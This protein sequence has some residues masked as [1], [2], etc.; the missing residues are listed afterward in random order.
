MSNDAHKAWFPVVGGGADQLVEIWAVA[1]DYSE[2]SDLIYSADHVSRSHESELES[3]VRPSR[4]SEG[5]NPRQLKRMTKLGFEFESHEVTITGESFGLATVLV[6]KMARYSDALRVRLPALVATATVDTKGIVGPFNSPDQKKDF[7]KKV[8][9]IVAK[10][11]TNAQGGVFLVS[12]QQ[13]VTAEQ[14]ESLKEAGIRLERIGHI[15]E[16]F[17]QDWLWQFHPVLKTKEPPK[18]SSPWKWVAGAASV[19]MAAFFIGTN[20]TPESQGEGIVPS[21]IDCKAALLKT[22]DLLRCGGV[23]ARYDLKLKFRKSPTDVFSDWVPGITLKEKQQF[24]L[25]FT[26]L[27]NDSR[28][29]YL[30]LLS[31]YPNNHTDVADLMPMPQCSDNG[32]GPFEMDGGIHDDLYFVATDNPAPLIEKMHHLQNASND[33]KERWEF[34]LRKWLSYE[35]GVKSFVLR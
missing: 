8:S 20:Q 1:A 14:A 30:L 28:H 15:D 22:E 32:C 18:P 4:S 35:P 33:A 34:E 17:K 21:K 5:N 31:E 24:R 11:K 23:Q 10:L 3:I 29:I 6:D 16:I 9:L 19:A 27:P 13:E 7:A 2:K 12:A 26:K 25:D